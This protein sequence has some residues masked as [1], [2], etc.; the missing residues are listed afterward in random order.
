MV[1][2]DTA[3]GSV[4]IT[5]KGDA[6]GEFVLTGK[7]LVDTPGPNGGKLSGVLRLQITDKGQ[8]EPLYDGVVADFGS[9]PLGEWN[10]EEKRTYDFRVDFPSAGDSTDNQYQLS[11]AKLTF[12]WDATQAS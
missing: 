10:P 12:V 9:V 5:N 6:S 2:G 4:S 3:T 8:Q 1:P 11:S 7:D